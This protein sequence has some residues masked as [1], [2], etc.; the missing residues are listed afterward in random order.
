[1]SLALPA[2]HGRP[3]L[4]KALND[5][6]GRQTSGIRERRAAIV[7]LRPQPQAA[8]AVFDFLLAALSLIGIA[9]IICPDLE[10]PASST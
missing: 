4:L 3:S 7:P 9:A 8:G 10:D 1:M 5:V 2:T 6:P